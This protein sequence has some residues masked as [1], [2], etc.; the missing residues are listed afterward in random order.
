[1]ANQI[2][3]GDMGRIMRLSADAIDWAGANTLNTIA[4]DSRNEEIPDKL[5]R[6][7]KLKRKGRAS[8]RRAAF[9]QVKKANNKKLEA[10]LTS[11]RGW[12]KYHVEDGI[13]RPHIRGWEFA[14]RKWIMVPYEKKAFRTV[15]RRTTLRA[16]YRESLV[17]IPD[18]SN[19]ALVFYR[20]NRG[21]SRDLY[22]IAFLVQDAKHH[23]DFEFE[24][25]IEDKLARDGDRLLRL[26]LDYQHKRALRRR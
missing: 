4:F 9:F 23:K 1:M 10:V 5:D 25:A 7:L 24:K 26:N 13:R 18:G 11:T 8:A 17:T 16:R 12:L 20:P 22:L 6:D 21:R 14:G 15:R 2:G 3:V 19:R